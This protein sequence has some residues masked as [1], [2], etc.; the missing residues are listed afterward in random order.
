MLILLSLMNAYC[1]KL[2]MC[3]FDIFHI[4]VFR[5]RNIFHSDLSQ[6]DPIA[7]IKFQHRG[8]QI[9]LFI[10]QSKPCFVNRR[11][12]CLKVGFIGKKT[13]PTR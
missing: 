8:Y 11:L 13:K 10:A 7:F 1:F 2:C 12:M 5:N 6:S 4:F 3:H 9:R